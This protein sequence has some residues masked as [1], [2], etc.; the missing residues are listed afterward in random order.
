L[1]NLAKWILFLILTD[2]AALGYFNSVNLP[3]ASHAIVE[4]SKITDYLLAF[5]HPEGG[6]K[7]EFFTR[8]GFSVD[9]WQVLSCALIDHARAHQVSSILENPYGTKYRVD[10][11]IQCPDGRSPRIRAV[12]IMDRGST[13]PRL[14]TA[15]PI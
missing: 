10:G 13:V 6:A 12:W 15:Y 2:R 3:N 11:Q 9:R 4:A 5:D 1:P 14:V 7:A 8:F